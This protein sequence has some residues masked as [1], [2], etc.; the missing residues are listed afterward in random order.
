MPHFLVGCLR[1]V[2]DPGI[3]WGEDIGSAING[4]VRGFGAKKLDSYV[5]VSE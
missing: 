4:R 1:P 5:I 3:Q 2:A